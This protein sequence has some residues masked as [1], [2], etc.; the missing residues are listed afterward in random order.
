M[1]GIGCFPAGETHI[2]SRLLKGPSWLLDGE[3]MTEGQE[4][5]LLRVWSRQRR[6]IFQHSW[7]HWGAENKSLW[8]YSPVRQKHRNCTSHQSPGLD[9]KSGCPCQFS[10]YNPHFCIHKAHHHSSLPHD[11]PLTYLYWELASLSSA[12][13]VSITQVVDKYLLETTSTK[14]IHANTVSVSFIFM[15]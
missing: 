3:G 13:R 10:S 12:I 14:A 5:Q 8:I 11:S 1:E 7:R 2:W 15:P 4:W 9:L 6:W